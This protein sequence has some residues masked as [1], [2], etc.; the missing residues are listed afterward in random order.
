MEKIVPEFGNKASR[1]NLTLS[2]EVVIVQKDFEKKLKKV[3]IDHTLSETQKHNQIDLLLK[4][5]AEE[6]NKA[7]AKTATA[8]LNGIN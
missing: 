5:R 1:P 7:S 3:L 8:A 6:T 4:E 2:K